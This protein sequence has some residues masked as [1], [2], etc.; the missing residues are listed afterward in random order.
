MIKDVLSKLRHQSLILNRR[1]TDMTSRKRSMLS[2]SEKVKCIRLSEKGLPVRKIAKEMKVGKSQIG[3]ILGRK[4]EILQTF[5]SGEVS[6][7]RRKIV[8]NVKPILR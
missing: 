4:E 5:S 6:S 3:N 1:Q 8:G 7:T 2:L